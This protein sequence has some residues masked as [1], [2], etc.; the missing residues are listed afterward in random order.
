MPVNIILPEDTEQ[1]ALTL[2]GKKRN[3]KK[4]DFIEFATN[5]G[6]REKVAL[7]LI[8]SVINRK[9]IL[10]DLCDKSYLKDSQ[11]AAFKELIIKRIEVLD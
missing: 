2:H 9:E 7:N 1:T 11:I 3:L 8:N 4:K 6:L 10:L 5:I